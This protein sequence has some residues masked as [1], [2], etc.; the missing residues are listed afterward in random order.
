MTAAGGRS[1]PAA[2]MTMVLLPLPDSPISPTTSPG[3]TVSETAL[4]ASTGPV[5]V[6]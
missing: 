5:G 6:S 4:T 2:A 3:A 1:S